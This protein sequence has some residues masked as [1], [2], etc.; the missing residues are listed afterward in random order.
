MTTNISALHALGRSFQVTANNI[1]NMNTHGF[2]SS[3]VDLESGPDDQGVRVQDIVEQTQSGPLVPRDEY[4][5]ENDE[6]NCEQKL[7]EGSNTDLVQEM[8]QMIEDEQAMAA[9]AQALQVQMDMD[10]DMLGSFIDEMV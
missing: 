3:R 8:V 6:S 9:N 4:V 2:H 5:R 7:V 1:A 10:M